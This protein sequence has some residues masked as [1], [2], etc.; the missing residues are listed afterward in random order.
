MELLK[1]LFEPILWIVISALYAHCAYKNYKLEKEVTSLFDQ[2]TEIEKHFYTY[3]I[4]EL[5]YFRKITLRQGKVIN[6]KHDTQGVK[7]YLIRSSEDK[8]QSAWFTEDELQID[9]PR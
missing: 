1:A 3:N 2:R 8:R 7:F 6:R 4:G 9:N 5:L